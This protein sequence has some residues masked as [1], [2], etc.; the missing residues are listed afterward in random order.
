MITSQLSREIFALNLKWQKSL[1]FSADGSLPGA[2]EEGT[3]EA[4][5]A[6]LQAC[7]KEIQEKWSVEFALA[8]DGQGWGPSQDA[9]AAALTQALLGKEG[10][11][12]TVAAAA[13]QKG[14]QQVTLKKLA[15]DLCRTFVSLELPAAASVGSET[16]AELTVSSGG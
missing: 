2:S 1:E 15:L 12:G 7:A 11:L 8:K 3:L 16:L 10:L 4:I 14:P 6:G 13:L 9:A 5:A